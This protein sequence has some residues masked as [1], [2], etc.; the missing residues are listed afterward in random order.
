[1]VGRGDL[2]EGAWTRMAALV[3]EHGGRGGPWRDQRTVLNGILWTRRTGAPGRDLPE[4][5]GAWQTW[6]DRLYRWRRTGLWDRLLA[7]AQA[8]TD[9]VGAVVWQV[10]VDAPMGRA[11]Q[12]ASGARHRPSVAAAKRGLRTRRTRR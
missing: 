11:Q 4:R 7:H 10:S 12:H 2:T 3:P 5:Y 1:M 8:R 6:A 9:A